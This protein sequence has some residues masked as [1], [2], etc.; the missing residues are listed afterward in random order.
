[1]K[2]LWLSRYLEN[3]E[4][5]LPGSWLQALYKK[6]IELNEFEIAFEF[7]PLLSL[8]ERPVPPIGVNS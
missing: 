5:G 2:V 3:T 4:N 8:P 6:N 7:A 1:M